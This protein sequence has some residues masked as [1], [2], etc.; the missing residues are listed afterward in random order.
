MLTQ[1]TAKLTPLVYCQA[2][3]TIINSRYCSQL[4]SYGP[5]YKQMRRIRYG[6]ITVD[7]DDGDRNSFIRL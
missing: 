6:V 7:E 2:G 3:S 1:Y 4:E 5:L